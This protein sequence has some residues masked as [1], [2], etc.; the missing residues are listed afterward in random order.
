M[1]RSLARSSTSSV[2]VATM[3]HPHPGFPTFNRVDDVCGVCPS[4]DDWSSST[5]TVKKK[6]T[7]KKAQSS[8]FGVCKNRVQRL[9]SE[10][11]D[12]KIQTVGLAAIAAV[13]LIAA[14]AVYRRRG[15]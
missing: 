12:S 1:Q 14:A 8:L 11:D 5:S 3:R 9:R 10:N 13:A 2:V 4:G 6:T 7:A 15:S